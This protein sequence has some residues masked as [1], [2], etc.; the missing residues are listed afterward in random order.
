MKKTYRIYNSTF[1]C[2]DYYEVDYDLVAKALNEKWSI[3]E[4]VEEI[5]MGID[6]FKTILYFN[7]IDLKYEVH[8][9]SSNEF[10]APPDCYFLYPVYVLHGKYDVPLTYEEIISNNWEELL[11]EFKEFKDFISTNFPKY[12]N[13]VPDCDTTEEIL[14]EI[15][16]I[17]FDLRWD[18]WSY[19]LIKYYLSEEIRESFPAV[20][21]IRSYI[22]E[23]LEPYDDMNDEEED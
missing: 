6:G 8:L 21:N 9:L 18:L 1:S 20:A 7:P 10:L 22:E 2:Y 4:F 3:D 17:Y 12:L 16:E 23:S 11:E 5:G 15:D 19:C 13:D 14:D